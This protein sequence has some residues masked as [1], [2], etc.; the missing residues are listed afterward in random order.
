[1]SNDTKPTPI[2]LLK[3]ISPDGA[4]TYLEHRT[5]I[6]D[7]PRFQALPLKIK[8]L[9][10]IGVAAALQSST[11]TLMW[12]KLAKEEGANEA[13]IVEAVLVSRLM[14]MATVNDTAADGLAWL[15]SGN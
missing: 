3:A 5:A 6:M 14:K 1:M 9:V 10:G 12:T 11:C 7:N 13:E 2:E 8:L 15:K 4:R